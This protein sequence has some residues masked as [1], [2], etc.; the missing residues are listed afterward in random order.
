MK[1]TILQ[2]AFNGETFIFGPEHQNR[3]STSFEVVLQRNGSGGGNALAHRHPCADETFKVRSGCLAVTV[4]GVVHIVKTG[5][6]ITVARGAPHFFKNASDGTT[7]FEC[8][9]SPPQSQ[10]QF[11]L[12]FGLLAQEHPE[13]FSRQ[14]DPHFLLIAL[15]L[16]NFKDHLYLAGIPIRL[17]KILFACAAP[18]ARML[19]YSLKVPPKKP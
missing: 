4:D 11:F 18:V 15:V 8:T 17:Q 9:F 12:N 7:E 16:H 19:G 13:W 3:G 10:R 5:E 6:S 2:N 14:G 1:S